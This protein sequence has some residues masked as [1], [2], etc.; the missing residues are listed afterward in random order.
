MDRY[1]AARGRTRRDQQTMFLTAFSACT[2]AC[3]APRPRGRAFPE[4]GSTS[5][6]HM[7]AIAFVKD[8]MAG[9][10]R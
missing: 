6:V 10:R 9:E 3:R 2:S 7:A 1:I 8:Q 4:R 5:V